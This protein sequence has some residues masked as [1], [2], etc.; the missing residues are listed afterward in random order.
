[1]ILLDDCLCIGNVVRHQP[2]W[3]WRQNIPGELGQ[4]PGCW[5]PDH[6]CHQVSNGNLVLNMMDIKNNAWV[7]VNNDFWSRV[8][9][10]ANN[11]HEWQSQEWRSLANRLT[12]DPQIVIHGNKCIISFLHAIWCPEHTILLKQLSISDFAI[13]TKGSLFWFIIVIISYLGM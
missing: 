12:S 4:Y 11:F 8:R 3:C 13:V 5:C 10:F 7:T 9:R 1:M 6:L 2:F